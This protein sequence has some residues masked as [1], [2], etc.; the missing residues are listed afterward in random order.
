MLENLDGGTNWSS[1]WLVRKGNDQSATSADP[2]AVGSLT[3]SSAGR[4]DITHAGAGGIRA[5]RQ[6]P[7]AITDDG[8]TYYMSWY[9]NTSY[10][11][12]EMNGSVAQVMIT[13]TV[14]LGAGGPAGQRVRMGKIF[15][16]ERFGIDG[17]NAGGN[18]FIDGTDTRE[19]MFVV[20]KISFSGD[21][22]VDPVRIYI[23]PSPDA[24]ALDDDDANAV[25]NANL[26][27]GFDGFGFKVEGGAAL[28]ASF[29][30]FRFGRFLNG[31]DPSM[32]VFPL[33]T[34]NDYDNGASLDGG[35]GGEGWDG[36]W[37]VF[38]EQGNT[39]IRDAGLLNNELAAGT[40]GNS[41][42]TVG[43]GMTQQVI[44][45]LESPLDTTD[46]ASF[47]FSTHLSL[48]GNIAGSVGNIILIDS[49]FG[50]NQNRVILGKQF[51]SRNFFATGV[52][53]GN[54][55]TG[56][57]FEDGSARFAVG[58]MTRENGQWLLDLFVDPNP[59]D[60][61]P[62]E[63]TA[64]I[65]NK[66]Y[67]AGNFN[68]VSIRVAGGGSDLNWDVDDIYFGETFEDVIPGD[69]VPITEAPP[70]ATESFDYTIGGSL[71][72][73]AGGEGF[74]GPW[75]TV[76]ADG[77]ATE[78]VAEGI[79][80]LPRLKETVGPS[81]KMNAYQRLMRP[82][83]GT[84]GD[85]GREFWL[86]WW[87]DVDM[88]GAN[89]VQF[90]LA[91][92]TVF[93]TGTGGEV[94]QI[95]N[96]FGGGTLGIVPGGNIA[97]AT[98]EDGHFFVAHVIT[99]GTADPDQVIVWVDPDL[100]TI[101]S[102]DTADV[103]TMTDL[104]NWNG[105]G[106]KFGGNP[107]QP[108]TA[109]FDEIRVASSFAEVVPTT[110]DI[111]PPSRVLAAVDVFDY[112]A[113]IELN[114]A[115]GGDGWGGPWMAQSGVTLVA[116]GNTLSD[117]TCPE[118]NQAS[119]TQMG[120]GAENPTVI[121]R[122][123]FNPYGVTGEGSTFYASAVI[124]ITQKDIGNNALFNVINTSGTPIISVGGTR[125]LDALAAI[126]NNDAANGRQTT[127]S[128]DAAGAKWI[129]IRMD[130]D[131]PAGTSDILVWVDP[132]ADA[133]PNDDNA[134]F[135]F[136]AVDIGGGI[137]GISLSALGFQNS[138]FTA[139]DIRVGS[140]YRDVSCQFGS[141]DPNLI[142]YEPFN[143]DVG[144]ALEG[145]GGINAFWDGT[146]EPIMA[147]PNNTAN[148]IAGSVAYE[149]IETNG[150]QVQFDFNTDLEQLDYR[151]ELAFPLES[152]SRTYW[153][154]WFQN[155]VVPDATDNIGNIALVN[156]EEAARNGRRLAFGRMFGEGTLGSVAIPNNNVRRTETPDA[157]LNWIVVKIVTTGDESPVDTVTMWINPPVGPE[158]D[159]F[160]TG[161]A[162]FYGTP[163]LKTGI[164]VIEL[165]ANGSGA[166]Q[167]PYITGFDEF[168]IATAWGSARL[169]NTVNV[170]A[171]D[172]FQLSAYPNPTSSEI[173]IEYELERPGRVAV[174]LYSMTGQLV[175]KLAEGNRSGGEQRTTLNLAANSSIT[176]GIYLLRVTHEGKSTTR[177]IMIQR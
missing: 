31:D 47:W 137:D 121:T 85:T 171:N 23:N 4:L 87:M 2:I 9:M 39:I 92:T 30:D 122:E 93:A 14:A 25:I 64:N 114:G 157:G 65:Q 49:T 58:H 61:E 175:S 50:D 111:A 52:G 120:A 176:N 158:P 69:L 41:A 45:Y 95:G 129:V 76:T 166:N 133:L 56:V 144:T 145:A 154:T 128:I 108:T 84:Y 148:I 13:N 32:A 1:D 165:R 15:G 22:E 40:S 138:T 96:K 42:R 70:G 54:T 152:D 115:E 60:G 86:G 26:N 5:V 10:E 66:A 68:A 16:T 172:P 55:Q 116:A 33:E 74:T 11:D 117:R 19:P 36:P 37:Q 17:I 173:T 164:D 140:S 7:N 126:R 27:A 150:N 125:G 99:N 103:M 53:A 110:T 101:P 169:T 83:E 135:S 12:P 130:V 118:G 147:Q 24:V 136:D 162:Q 109:R 155:T 143:Y 119:I 149:G 29:D 170:A 59:A 160:S 3:T 104:S 48:S 35:T 127:N 38:G 51:G 102:A 63:E 72:G 20:A 161:F 82:L 75:V 105:I 71:E 34:F 81:V 113:G 57:Q 177:K 146:W 132:P 46:N 88:P 168:R 131:V 98:A 112:D 159:T 163:L 142:A 156:T 67:N 89:V 94:V 100:E 73:G 124:D 77:D 139:D 44:R 43:T 167:S 97:D 28:E 106:L 90:V 21:A 107:D 134:V 153:L 18:T 123:L 174:E 79:Q 80:S 151:R 62:A 78:I 91:D 141:D 8:S 6:L